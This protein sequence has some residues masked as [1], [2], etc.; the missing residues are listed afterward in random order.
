MSDNIELVFR[1]IKDRL[2]EQLLS[3]DQI[4]VKYNYILGFNS[5][6]LVLLLQ[7]YLSSK[8]ID[9]FLLKA[10]SMFFLSIVITLIG[11]FIRSYRRD[12]DPSGLYN[13]KDKSVS[14]TRNQLISNY[15]AC[16][17]Y[18][19]KRIKIL[20][21]LYKVAII[22]T[23][24]GVFIIFIYLIKGGVEEWTMKMID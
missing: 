10:G 21:N 7:V 2:K 19:K 20:K 12:P 6:I 13:Y 4:N 15:I 23:T 18:N 17:D 8:T 3:I 22:I 16:F 11:L 1:E 24:V 14:E 5:I 9:I